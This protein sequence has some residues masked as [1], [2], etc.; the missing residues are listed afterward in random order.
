MSVH[1]MLCALY[2]ALYYIKR[3]EYWFNNIFRFKSESA[4]LIF[5]KGWRLMGQPVE[6]TLIY[7]QS[8]QLRNKYDNND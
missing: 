1:F 6:S 4:T 7:M 5:H 3:C 2:V 8:I